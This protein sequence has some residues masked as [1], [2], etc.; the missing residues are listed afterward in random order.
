M[1]P[2]SSG[3]RYR[4]ASTARGTAMTSFAIAIPQVVEHGRFD[5]PSAQ[6]FLRRADELG[7]ESGW[8]Q[9][10]VLGDFPDLAPM[11]T[12]AYAAACTTRMR[13]GGA[14]LVSSLHSP[15]HLALSIASV[16]QLS[17]GRL[18]VGL[19]TGGGYRPFAAFGVERSSYVARFNEG[20][21]LMRRMWTEE[22]V[23]HD[24]RFWQLADAAMEPKPVQ[25][26]GP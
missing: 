3:G 21:A 11:E 4:R 25:A 7:F 15:L 10:Q 18:E 6:A 14:V 19:G 16:D 9:E 17:G 13:L 20:L 12:L 24:G 8:T 22:R 5:G 23:D 2:R 26:G 1:D